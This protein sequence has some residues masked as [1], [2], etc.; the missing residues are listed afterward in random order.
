MDT[1]DRTYDRA[2]CEIDDILNKQ[3][4]DKQDVEMLYSFID[5]VKDIYEI[6]SHQDSMGYSQM[7]GRSG[8]NMRGRSGRMMPM[9]DRNGSYVRDGGY[10]RTSN[11]DVMLDH[12]QDVMDMAVDEKDR[13]AVERLMQQMSER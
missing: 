9:Y 7:D 3:K 12:L 8:T 4:F 11:K 5:I 13:K 6:D 10:S 1:I 2:C